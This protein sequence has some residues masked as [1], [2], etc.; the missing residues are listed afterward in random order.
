MSTITTLNP[1]AISPRTAV[2]LLTALTILPL[3]LGC[4]SALGGRASANRPLAAGVSGFNHTLNSITTFSINGGGGSIGGVSCCV[5]LPAKWHPN[6]IAKVSWESLDKSKLSP[7]P[8][9]D[10]TEAYKRWEAELDKYTTQHTAIVPV[11]KYTLK[12]ACSMKVH[13]LPCHQVKVTTSCYSYLDPEY[14]IQEPMKMK[15]PILCP[16]ESQT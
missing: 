11:P 16:T 13:F 4:A 5:M 12:D 8:D 10:Q 1:R 6:F 2:M 14:P 7:R 15:E 3:L 9:F